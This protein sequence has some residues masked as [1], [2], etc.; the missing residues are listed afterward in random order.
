MQQRSV[1]LLALVGVL[2]AS[3]LTAALLQALLPQL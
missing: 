3:L 2:I 1:L